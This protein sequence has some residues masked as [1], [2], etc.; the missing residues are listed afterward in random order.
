LRAGAEA[1][2][3]LGLDRSAEYL[4]HFLDGSGQDM[5]VPRDEA[6]KDPFINQGEKKNEVPL[7][8]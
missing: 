3:V 4:K 8:L 7:D 5:V 6:R 2:D 1:G